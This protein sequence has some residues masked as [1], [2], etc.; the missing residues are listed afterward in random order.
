[1]KKITGID[2]RLSKM[3]RSLFGMSNARS[4]YEYN[5]AIGNKGAMRSQI[6]KLGGHT[7]AYNSTKK[8]R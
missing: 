1:M 7:A 4:G 8:G 3:G 5:K 6:G 2:N